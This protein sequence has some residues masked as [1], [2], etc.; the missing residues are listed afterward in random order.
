[1]TT[2]KTGNP[3]GSTDARDRLDNSEN[4]DI[5]ENSTT[6]LM[7]PDRLGTMRKTRKGMELE[8]DNQISAHETAFKQ[9]ISQMA[10]VR[11]G[12]FAAG[13]NS[14]TDM[15][16]TLL[17]SNGHEYGWTGAFPKTVPAGATPTTSGGIGAGAWVD[18]T[19]VT[20]RD[21]L[22]RNIEDYGAK[23]S[24]ADNSSFINA[25]ISAN[26]SI[27]LGVENSIYDVSTP[28][29]LRGLTHITGANVGANGTTQYSGVRKTTNTEVTIHNQEVS[30]I[31]IDTLFYSTGSYEDSWFPTGF[32]IE[33][34]SMTSSTSEGKCAV[35]CIQGSGHNWNNVKLY[36]FEY[37]F[38]SS[39]VWGSV[40][41]D[42]VTN[43]KMRFQNGT[44]VVLNR[45]AAGGIRSSG[46]SGGFEFTN[47]YYSTLNSCSS[48]GGLSSA[49]IFKNSQGIVMNGCGCESNSTSDSTRGFGIAFE[50]YNHIQVNGFISINPPLPETKPLFSIRPGDRI[51][52]NGG[53][54]GGSVAGSV[55]NVDIYVHDNGCSAHFI[56]TRFSDLTNVPK[57]KWGSAVNP[58]GGAKVYVTINGLTVMYT[59]SGSVGTETTATIAT[60]LMGEYGSNSNGSYIKHNDGILECWH[61]L[62]L[63]SFARDVN[64]TTTVQSTI[65]YK[66]GSTQWTYPFPFVNALP[67]P[68][69]SVTPMINQ[70]YIPP[71]V[72]NVSNDGASYNVSGVVFLTGVES[73]NSTSGPA[74]S[75]LQKVK[76][77]AIG[78]WSTGV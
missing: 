62:P 52:F 66:S 56:D 30:D 17:A 7:H 9:R 27:V 37:A 69:V 54:F 28:I 46:G 12:T 23:N 48:D 50:G 57:I 51:T 14:L 18:R 26:R 16:Q 3:I 10:F 29:E 21:V 70:F 68:Q 15:R 36:N 4:M 61:E 24:N 67:F 33:N 74:Y 58:I 39:Q 44:S 25:A 2:Y 11:V 49:Y 73:F 13:Y 45:V 6:E 8:H 65:Y 31:T 75:A 22:T 40:F 1:M 38:D 71:I 41:E 42:V 78:R 59:K 34:L 19:D 64:V 47:F 76:V 72:A 43:G 55:G 5:L 77:R 35:Y 60:N 63:S 20:L 53:E 32:K